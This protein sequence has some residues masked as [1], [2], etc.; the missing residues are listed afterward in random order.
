LRDR[1]RLVNLTSLSFSP[2]VG[3]VTHLSWGVTI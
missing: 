3:A 2:C 1:R